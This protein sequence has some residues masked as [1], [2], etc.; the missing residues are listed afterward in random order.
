MIV[1]QDGLPLA[2]RY[3]SVLV[4]LLGITISALDSTVMNLALPVMARSLN[5]SAA[6]SVWIIN[7]FQLGALILLLPAAALGD[8]IGYR[9]VYLTGAAVFLVASVICFVAPNLPVLAG[10]RALQ[11]MGAAGIMAANSALVRLTYPGRLFG[12]GL[13]LNAAIVATATVAGPLVAASVLSVASWHWLFALNV[14]VCTVILLMGLR[15]L[16]HNVA[17]AGGARRLSWLDMLL[18]AS[19]F[20]LIFLGVHEFA[21]SGARLETMGPAVLLFGAGLVV[22]LFYLRRQLV[23]PFPLLPIALLRIPIF[24]LSICT[25]VSSFAAQTL[26]FIAVPFLILEVW[27]QNPVQAGMIMTAWPIALVVVAPL[28]GR[29]IGRYPG[30]LLGGIGLAT[31]ATGMALLALLATQPE[32]PA[33]GDIAWRMAVCGIGFGLFQS[34]NNYTIMSSA[35]HNL[36]GAAGGM[37]ATARLTG[38]SVGSI[39]MVIIFSLASGHPGRAPIIALS[40]AAAFASVAAAFSLL[41]LRHAAPSI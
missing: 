9:R 2:A 14:P 29:L 39:L 19:M 35:P 40:M 30:G 26:T 16:P 23:V 18:N 24:S 10:A 20:A 4:L 1:H 15:V 33:L 36:M 21:A 34:P 41:R 37:L 38:Q 13:A 11:G 25:S 27:H 5:V 22:G 3:R 28:A 8:L 12:R 31:M 6:D 32:S 7:A 17:P